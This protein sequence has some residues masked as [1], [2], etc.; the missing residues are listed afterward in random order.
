MSIRRK[1]FNK[2]VYLLVVVTVLFYGC[3][4]QYVKTDSYNISEKGKEKNYYNKKGK[5][6]QKDK[7]KFEYI[8]LPGV[9][10]NFK[11]SKKYNNTGITK[12]GKKYKM[13]FESLDI[14]KFIDTMMTQV[15]KKNYVMSAKLKSFKKN[16]SIRMGK[17]VEL[18]ELFSIFENVLSVNGV[19][20]SIK[21]KTY[22]FDTSPSS[23]IPLSGLVLFG[24]EL[25]KGINLNSNDKV[26]FII[27]FYIL[28]TQ[29]FM[30]FVKQHLSYEAITK[31]L[32]KKMFLINDQWKR[33]KKLLMVLEIIDK[34]FLK[35]KYIIQYTP[36]YWDVVDLKEQ[37]DKLMTFE[38]IPIGG[39]GVELFPIEKLNALILMSN[40]K[41]WLDRFVFWIKNLDKPGTIGAKRKVFFYRLKNT[42]AEE[43]AN[44]LSKV[45]LKLGKSEV[46]K[47]TKTAQRSNNKAGTKEKEVNTSK[48]LNTTIIPIKNINSLVIIDTPENYQS[49]HSLLEKIDVM[50]NQILLELI[51]AEIT[52]TN[53]NNLGME[54]FLNEYMYD[55]TVETK[56]GVGTS[57]ANVVI[58]G[59]I[60]YHKFKVMINALTKKNILNV[61]HRP[62]M[63]AVENE[64]ANLHVG[65][66][67]PIITSAV[68]G[69]YQQSGNSQLMRSVDYRSTGLNINL[70]PLIL[71]DEN[72]Q[73]KLACEISE[74]QTN[75]ISP[76]IDSPLIL[77]RTVDTTLIIPESQVAFISGVFQKSISQTVQGIPVL[78]KIPILGRLFKNDTKKVQKTELVIF[79]NARIIKN[80]NDLI[81]VMRNIVDKMGDKGQ[82]REV[83]NEKNKI[84]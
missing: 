30:Q 22:I 5:K 6:N 83:K 42:E 63:M 11:D 76:T 80:R 47:K 41:D 67:V 34:P 10:A 56:T 78:S 55:T 25:P 40:E 69:N 12:N 59:L 28:N 53:D 51:I 24:R 23:D 73:I 3:G 84:K 16:I 61:L 65:T 50:R 71:S 31:N 48:E 81:E 27:P 4:K 46:K 26:T 66:E 17:D 68:S 9:I 39:D 43:T 49:I 64:A 44:V 57:G 19:Y 21:N 13:D 2:L 72:I 75:S 74:A 77:S 36:T 79:V 29:Q 7:N 8:Q 58:N 37:V 14:R 45:Y 35:G 70:T 82:R 52:I 1:L 62:I 38:G 32:G 54:F 18:V 20:T 33:I 15:F 60:P